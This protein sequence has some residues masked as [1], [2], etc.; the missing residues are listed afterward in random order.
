MSMVSSR[1]PVLSLCAIAGAAALLLPA[2]APAAGCPA[3]ACVPRTGNW[4]GP[5]P[6]GLTT[7][8]S[9][10]GP[11][12]GQISIVVSYRKGGAKRKSAYGNTVEDARTNVRYS[13][14]SKTNPWVESGVLIPRP[15]RIG[16]DGKARIVDPA[17]AAAGRGVH[18]WTFKFKRDTVT[19]TIAGSYRSSEGEM[20]KVSTGFRAK[21][22][23]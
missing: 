6:Q 16:S 17:D 19:G 18:T 12:A 3:S 4:Q 11:G 15:G 8:D 14:T 1:S 20:C 23:A 10:Y 5:S 9:L 21:L 7:L 22:K 13:C 2:S